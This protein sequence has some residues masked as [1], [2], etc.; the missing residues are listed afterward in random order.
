MRMKR[1][2][3]AMAVTAAYATAAQA[4]STVTIYGMED[5]YIEMGN[6]GKSNIARL[7]SGGV[8][9]S[10]LGFMGSEELGGGLRSVF[11]MEAGFNNDDGSSGQ[12]GI[13]FGRQA[14]MGLKSNDYGSITM[15]RQYAAFNSNLIVYGLGGGLAWGNASNYFI[16]LSI[17]RVNNSLAYSSPSFGGFT[18]AGTYGFGENAGDTRLSSTRSVG[19]QYTNGAFSAGLSYLNRGT[20]P[21]N[22]ERFILFG[23]SYD[24]NVAKLGMLYQTRRDGISQVENDF[25]ELGVT[26]PLNT[27]SLLV[28][29]GFFKNK[30]V[31]NADAKVVSLRYD[32][33]L[34]KRTMLYTGIAKMWNQ[35]KGTHGINGNTSVAFTVAP[36]EDPRSIVFG[37]RH[38]F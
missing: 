19:T 34:S 18:F 28:D 13:F 33:Y 32:Y 37:M 8:S 4:Q 12:G 20:T 7:Q 15:G 11:Q 5:S 27:S 1:I 23:A 36:G 26:I 17:L 9:G 31:A 2:V 3:L 30:D 29:Y 35:A 16:D 10:R 6:N 24:F 14:Y 25:A 38:T 21:V 22:D